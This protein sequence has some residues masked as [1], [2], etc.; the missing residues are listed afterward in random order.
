MKARILL[1]ALLAAV[2]TYGSS[3][4]NEGFLIPVNLSIN[5]C[6]LV[7]ST[8]IGLIN[9]SPKSFAL[10]TLIDES[11]RDNIKGAR[12]YDIRVS[13]TGNFTGNIVGTVSV[14]SPQ[15]PTQQVLLYV[16]GG[17]NNTNPVPWS[18]FS[19]PQTLLGASPYV[20][21][22]AAGVGVLVAALDRMVTDSNTSITLY[23]TG[24]TS[25]ATSLPSGLSV[26][27]EILGQ[28]DARINGGDGN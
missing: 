18:T 19:T 14:S 2:M 3:C 10:S 23:V 28:V 16:G 11:F 1:L 6:Y 26:C 25:G 15:S 13:S 17:A 5:N 21:T 7:T 4:I 24:Q 22:S 9:T 8:T 12:Y 20:R 27:V